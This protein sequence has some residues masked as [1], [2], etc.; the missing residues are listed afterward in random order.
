MVLDWFHNILLEEPIK[1]KSKN[2]VKSH[3][4]VDY[5]DLCRVTWNYIRYLRLLYVCTLHYEE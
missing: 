4:T 5:A 1:L 3:N 2:I